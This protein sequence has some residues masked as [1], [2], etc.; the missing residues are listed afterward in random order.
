MN[1][2]LSLPKFGILQGS[3]IPEA[4]GRLTGVTKTDASDKPTPHT[5]VLSSIATISKRKKFKVKTE[6]SQKLR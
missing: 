4:S 3:G 5:A 6:K 1:E 2:T